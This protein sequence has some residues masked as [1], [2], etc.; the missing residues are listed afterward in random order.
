MQIRMRTGEYATYAF[1]SFDQKRLTFELEAGKRDVELPL[2]E[3]ATFA[4]AP[5]DT[6]ATVAPESL[7]VVALTD[8]RTLRGIFR[9]MDGKHAS[10][11]LASGEQPSIELGT[12][13]YVAFGNGILD[14]DRKEFGNGFN[15]FGQE[16][17]VS[18]ADGYASDVATGSPMLGDSV[19]TE[20]MNALGRRIAATSKR[21]DLNY[22]FSVIDSH[23]ANAFTVGGG[24]VFI[25]RGLVEQIGSEA[26]LAG[27]LAHEI[28]H[29]VGKHV[30]KKLSETLLMQGIVSAGGALLAGGDEKRRKA[31]ESLGGAVAYFTTL[32]FSR[33]DEREA[34]YLGVYNLYQQGYDPHAMVSAFETLKRI[35]DHDPSALEVFFQ[36]HPSLN[37]RIENTSAEL[38]KLLLE[39]PKEDSPEFQAMKTRLTELPWPTL[40]RDLVNERIAVAAN[41]AQMW[42][43]TLDTAVL[44][45][46]VLKGHIVAAG[47]TG[48]D[49][50]VLLLDA[51]NYLNWKNGH[52]AKTLFNSGQITATDL[53]VPIAQSGQ[54]FLILDNRFSML[55]DK[56]V[57][58]TVFAEYKE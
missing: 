36:T 33:D 14:V 55:T 18:L 16:L 7:D 37:E 26:E 46:C 39:H 12:I 3:I 30:A 49:I 15:L 13:R 53:N 29:N 27:V 34:D 35:Y 21:P 54:Y 52:E 6:A 9:R 4:L 38:P 10:V 11:L 43:L 19:V 44:K 1:S 50:H 56:T 47:G 17:E 42:T 23:V 45:Q 58:V 25:Y 48:N 2:R 24:H 51:T 8:G 28:G 20:Y 22:S 41:G 40:R 31:L 57:A 5:S 32:K